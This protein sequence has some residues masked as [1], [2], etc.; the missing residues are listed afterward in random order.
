[1]KP[2]ASVSFE[3]EF[4]EQ[5]LK[6][7]NK[8]L[9]VMELLAGLYNQAG[10]FDKAIKIDRRIVRLDPKNPDA[11]YNLAC[12]L[13]L[14]GKIKEALE[15]LMFAVVCGYNDLQW[16]LKDPELAALQALPEFQAVVDFLKNPGTNG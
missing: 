11:H 6:H 2:N 13:A 1:V 3:I 8:H 15:T 10:Q 16:L 7:Y 12:S 5:I 14:N 9:E 4:F